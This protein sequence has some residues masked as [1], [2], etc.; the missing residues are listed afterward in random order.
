MK[1][2]SVI[3]ALILM[4]VS[5]NAQEAPADTSYWKAGGTFSFAFSPLTCF[6]Y[7]SR[8]AMITSTLFAISVFPSSYSS[9]P[10]P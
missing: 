7:A 2:V 10:I 8:T 6:E 3:T 9:V 4:A 1:S 5:V